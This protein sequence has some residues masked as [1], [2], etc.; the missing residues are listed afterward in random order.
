VELL[1]LPLVGWLFAVVSGMALAAGAWIVIGV[2]L[3]GEAP[4][5]HLAAR[6]LDD[7]ILFGIW[8][9]GLAGGVGV[10]LEKAWSRPVLEL[11][12]WALAVLLLLV[13]WQRLR[14]APPPRAG[15]ALSL[16]LFLVPVI[17]LCAATILTLRSE[18]ALRALA[19]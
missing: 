7:S 14:A 11:F 17:A 19:G 1:P 12:C 8:I 16:A 18:T 3:A 13:C 9:L 15:L 6:V 10:L 4:R 2:H 5:K